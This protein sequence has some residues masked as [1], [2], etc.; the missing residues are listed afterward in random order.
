MAYGPYG[1]AVPAPASRGERVKNAA[2]L[3]GGWVALLWVLEAIDVASGHALDTFGI[4]PREFGELRDIVP[5]AFV[6][7]GWDHLAANSVPLLLLGFLAALSGI[8][9]FLAVV[10]VTILV[11]GLGVW[12]TASEHS[13]TAGASGVVFGLFGY[14]LVRGFVDRRIGDVV[15]GLV[16]GAVYGSILWGVLPTTAGVSWQGHL[17]GLIGGV[18]SAFVFR[19]PREARA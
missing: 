16:V 7:F 3:V 14:L 8:R 11:S 9:R 10:T 13:I 4:T 17:F 18:A 19:R 12:L 5:A 2:L 6:H 15:I 1:V